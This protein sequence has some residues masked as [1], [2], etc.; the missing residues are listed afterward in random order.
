MLEPRDLLLKVIIII[1][2]KIGNTR[3]KKEFYNSN[4]SAGYILRENRKYL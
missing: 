2:I 1:I 4:G 3:Y